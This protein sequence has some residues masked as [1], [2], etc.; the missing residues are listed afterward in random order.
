LLISVSLCLLALFWLTGVLEVSRAAPASIWYVDAEMGSDGDDC[1][2]PASPCATVGA[3][4]GRAAAGDTIRVASGVYSENLELQSLT[5][6]GAG[7][8]S[9]ILDGAQSGR[10]LTTLLQVRI[11]DLT[12]RNGRLTGGGDVF[13]TGGAGIRNGG[14]LTLMNTKIVSNTTAGGGGGIFN[15]GSLIVRDTEI[16]GNTAEGTGGGI[17]NWG[18]ATGVTVT[19]SLIADN[20]ANQGGG[21]YSS[22]SVSLKD[23]TLHDNRADLFGGGLAMFSGSAELLNVTV[24][25]NHAESYGAGLLNNGGL[26][27]VTNSTVSENTAG[28]YSGIASISS[29]A[30]TMILNSTIV[31]NR[32]TSSAGNSAGGVAGINDATVYVQNTMVADN[33]VSDCTASGDWTSLGHNLASDTTCE[34][35]QPGDKQDVDPQ[36]G[37]LAPYGGQTLTYPPLAGSPAIDAG[38]DD[39]CP[40]KDQRGASRPIDVDGDGLTTC[41][42]GAFEMRHQ[43][44]ISDVAVDEG[45]S[46]ATNAVF[47]VSLVP[48]GTQPVT[49]TYTTAD[50]TASSGS[51]YDPA[52]GVLVFLPGQ[53]T[54]WITVTVHGDTEDEPDETFTVDLSAAQGADLIDDQ[55]LGTIVDDDG[56]PSLIIADEAFSEG[57]SGSFDAVF[58]VTLSPTSTQAVDVAYATADG[59][60]VSGRDYGATA[61]TLT[62]LPGQSTKTISVTITSDDLDEGENEAFLVHLTDASNATLAEDQAVGTI[63][64]DDTALIRIG[65][66]PQ[67]AEGDVGEATAVFE[68]ELTTPAAFTVTVDYHTYDGFGETGATGGE[69]YVPVSGTL[70]F[71]PEETVHSIPVAIKGDTAVEPDE[72]FWMELDNPDPV[73]IQL[74]VSSGRILNDDA[75]VVFLP[76]LLR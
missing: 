72:T 19:G 17:Y 64:D 55:G 57:D 25:E 31:K 14:T 12:V 9:T 56:L 3:A 67:V 73:S 58:T 53:A 6:I 54:Q 15:S 1:Q 11:K 2:T 20:S 38:D 8:D 70:A 39:S 37:P 47:I 66:G 36:L 65:A 52:D 5:L 76:T 44:S 71:A 23:T 4:V 42:I 26:L 75:F 62:F 7:P 16:R 30:Q 69:D 68:V 22:A 21:V 32:R 10:V 27:T 50:D 33:D 63:V 18:T 51:D 24:H 45:E 46:G 40:A 59:T 34:F 41:D 13:A 60:A 35:T 29:F 43:I 61:G 48:T 28:S 49:V 74:Q